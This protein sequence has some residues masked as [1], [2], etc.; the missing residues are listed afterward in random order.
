MA[1]S[2]GRVGRKGEERKSGTISPDKETIFHLRAPRPPCT[3]V[4][5][6]S[7]AAATGFYKSRKRRNVVV[8]FGEGCKNFLFLISNFGIDDLKMI[9]P[10]RFVNLL[11]YIDL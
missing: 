1:L 11:K 9:E 8:A 5:A 2:N 3:I 7:P 10:K 6:S 4:A